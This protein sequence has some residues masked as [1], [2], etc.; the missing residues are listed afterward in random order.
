MRR[1]P[2]SLALAAALLAVGVLALSAHQARAQRVD[3]VPRPVD[4]R[5]DAL[6]RTITVT[7]SDDIAVNPL[8]VLFADLHNVPAVPLL[9]V[10]LSVA[11][12]GEDV[13]FDAS[14]SKDELTI[15]V[16]DISIV[17]GQRV[18]VSYNHIF[19][20]D[21][22]ALLVDAQANPV[23]PFTSPVQ[24]LS[25]APPSTTPLETPTVSI[26][27]LQITESWAG[28]LFVTL[29]SRPE[30][31]VGV[32][33]SAWPAGTIAIETSLMTFTTENWDEPQ[34]ALITTT[35]DADSLD[36]W[37]LI[38]LTPAGAATLR[39]TAVRVVVADADEP[40]R[41]LG[42]GELAYPE[43]ATSSVATYGIDDGASV[44]WS[45]FGEDAER[46]TISRAG[47]LSFRAT[48]DHENPV[49]RDGDNVYRVGVHAI[50]ESSTGLL[51]VTVTAIDVN[52][53]PDVFGPVRVAVE[54]GS[55]TDVGRYSH[56]DPEDGAISWS[57]EGSDR[58]HF[59]IEGGE[60][61]FIAA[62]D[63]DSSADAN[64]NNRYQVTV[65]AEDGGGL[66]GRRLVTVSVR[67]RGRVRP[68]EAPEFPASATIRYLGAASSA[69]ARV[70]PP[71][72]AFDP[73]GDPLTYSFSSADAA[74]FHVDEH[75]GQIRVASGAAPE[76]VAGDSYAG[77]MT[78]TDPSGATASIVVR[79][80]V[81]AERPRQGAPSLPPNAA[82]LEW[83]VEHDLTSLDRHNDRPTGLS[84]D[85][86]TLWVAEHDQ[87]ELG[88][89]YAYELATGERDED[90]EFELDPANRAPS[91]IATDG[92]TA[93]VSDAGVRRLFAYDL[94][95][96]ERAEH[97]DIELDEGVER[98]HGLWYDQGAMW[99]AD[100]GRGLLVVH[101]LAG[102]AVLAEYWLDPE[103]RSPHGIWSDGATLWASDQTS[104]RLFAYGL[105]RLR[106]D[107]ER[108]RLARIDESDI[109]DLTKARNNS[110][111]GLWSDG[112]VLYVADVVDGR[113]YS[114]NLP[115]ASDTRLAGLELSEMDIG[116]FAPG[117]REYQAVVPAGVA[118]TTVEARA[119]QP[120]ATV[121][122][123]PP[124]ADRLANGHQA[125]VAD[126]AEI[127]VSVTSPDRS[128]TG[129]YR[130]RIEQPPPLPCLRGDV[131]P[132]FSLV[133]YE[134][135]SVDDLV[136]CASS[137]Q[138]TTLYATDA[139]ALVPYVLGAPA[140]VNRAFRALFAEG[141]P[142]D[143][144]LLAASDRPAGQ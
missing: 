18:S 122:I 82:D 66:A 9:R 60:L 16:R 34:L 71:V 112:G 91:G 80:V 83:T 20:R 32:N 67:E 98:A 133:V 124:D 56:D 55:G 44:T 85:G 135:G 96:G 92:T 7:F 41:I 75:T 79:I 15:A 87:G 4:V 51:P 116:T 59:S 62:P 70:G 36:A 110:P 65:R 119:A 106:R 90:A 99:V 123:S 29:P 28:A 132:G 114:Y 143:T 140:L 49:D 61:R 45:L 39:P 30:G 2:R 108:S 76:L 104:K 8:A 33:I 12:D 40:L 105:P 31:A 72:A 107:G 69:R 58:R 120:R 35:K 130:V 6:G 95:T 77:T 26:T 100:G 118:R 137:R 57:L 121:A 73:D 97:R 115:D 47:A 89:V 144:P 74:L 43:N 38:F 50:G 78:A 109:T 27:S 141:L 11:V 113:V 24:N 102:G 129:V 48:P 46:F 54:E 94:Q 10:A 5:T 17:S 19:G 126:G 101:E 134:G 131:A 125:Q 52:E 21:V 23:A 64:R 117:K 42:P 13:L 138:V 88:A 3:A 142:A 37:A 68:N 139:G 111:R 103:N 22:V 136:A 25:T 93:W 84:S 53:H 128:R 63:A 86:L 14:L 1:A 127:T 81:F